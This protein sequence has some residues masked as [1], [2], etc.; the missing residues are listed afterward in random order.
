MTS[1]S[2]VAECTSLNLHGVEGLIGLLNG[3]RTTRSIDD[4]VLDFSAGSSD[5]A[6]EVIV[7]A[8]SRASA[9]F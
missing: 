9:G 6:F 5:L 7:L 3:E 2:S 4:V 8:I 1:A